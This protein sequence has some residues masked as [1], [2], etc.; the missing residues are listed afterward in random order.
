MQRKGGA[1][2]RRTGRTG[3][4]GSGQRSL[5]LHNPRKQNLAAVFAQ[6]QPTAHKHALVSPPLSRLCG[7]L[8]GTTASTRPPHTF[9]HTHCEQT[10]SRACIRSHNR[11]SGHTQSISAIR[12]KLRVV[13][14]IFLGR[15]SASAPPRHFP[16]D[17]TQDAPSSQRSCNVVR[18]VGRSHRN[19]YI[20]QFF[21]TWIGFGIVMSQVVLQLRS[22]S[23]N[24]KL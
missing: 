7:F 10:R 20:V 16:S 13:G 6:P 19:S 23:L 14:H 22:V 8:F 2:A 15:V 4:R 18:G 3:R 17:S 9:V 24:S 1:R 5:V 12:R 21:G 11:V